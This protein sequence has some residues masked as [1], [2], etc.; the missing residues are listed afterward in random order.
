M[1]ICYAT[2]EGVPMAKGGPYTKI[3]EVKRHL[4]KMGNTVVM[5]DMWQSAEQLNGFDC[6]H[7]VGTNLSIFGLVRN[8]RLRNIKY[9]VEPVLYSRHSPA[10][11]KTFSKAAA[12]G[13]KAFPGLWH[14]YGLQREIC[15]SA[16]LI[17]PNTVAERDLLSEGFSIPK[18]KFRIIPNGVSEKFLKAKP[19]LFV[20]KFGLKN[21]ILTVGHIGPRR[22]NILRLVHALKNINR[23]AVIIGTMLY[24]D[25]TKRVK[26]EL[27][28]NTNILWIDELPNHS[29][30]L[31]S[32]YAACDV[33]VLPSLFETPGIAALEAGLAGAKI[34]LTPHGG[35]KEYFQDMAEYVEPKS[36]DSIRDGIFTALKKPKDDK[37]QK[38]IKANYLWKHVAKRTLEVYKSVLERS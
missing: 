32:A 36:I 5:F 37:L 14:E 24:G 7:V 21:F 38:H 11:L 9:F 34:V 17:L 18:E 27:A 25:E 1:K 28:Q 16:E 6:I 19:D 23:P 31:A 22:K 29:P 15:G 4:E 26:E 10:F 8:L 13:Q 12:L 2:Y 30:L 35:T 20:K 3:M 33:F